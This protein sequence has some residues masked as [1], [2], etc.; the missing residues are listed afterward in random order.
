M[1]LQ[2]HASELAHVKERCVCFLGSLG[3][4]TNHWLVTSSQAEVA[5]LAVAWDTQKHLR[6]EVPFMDIKPTI[7][8]GEYA[9]HFTNIKLKFEVIFAFT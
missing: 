4:S 5:K 1:V 6:F 3:G 9:D 8:F 7:Y 2:K